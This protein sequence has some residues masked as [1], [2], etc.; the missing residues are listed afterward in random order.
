MF[1]KPVHSFIIISIKHL[2]QITIH[3]FAS[4]SAGTKTHSVPSA[5]N[6]YFIRYIQFGVSPRWRYDIY[7]NRL[8]LKDDTIV[9]FEEVISILGLFKDIQITCNNMEIGTINIFW[10]TAVSRFLQIFLNVHMFAL[11]A[12]IKKNMF[13]GRHI[14]NIAREFIIIINR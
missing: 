6:L 12:I 4:L 11:F 14:V 13:R 8:W 7:S 10:V 5:F 3:S 1:G 2:R 9:L